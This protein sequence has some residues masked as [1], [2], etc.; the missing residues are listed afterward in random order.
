MILTV[1]ELCPYPLWPQ[2]SHLWGILGPFTVLYCIAPKF[3]KY[4]WL[5]IP[6]GHGLGATLKIKVDSMFL[7][8]GCSGFFVSL[9]VNI[10][11]LTIGVQYDNHVKNMITK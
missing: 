1:K 6:R 3:K 7:L 2:F 4:F 9:F 11:K 8:C 5:L 10:P